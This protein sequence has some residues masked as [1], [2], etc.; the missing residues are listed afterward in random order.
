MAVECGGVNKTSS[1][2]QRV[3]MHAHW[4]VSVLPATHVSSSAETGRMLSGQST[5]QTTWTV[6]DVTVVAV[7]RNRSSCCNVICV[8]WTA[9]QRHV[10]VRPSIQGHSGGIKWC[11]L[12]DNYRCFASFSNGRCVGLC[13]FMQLL[14]QIRSVPVSND[15]PQHDR[16]TRNVT[17][18]GV[19]SLLLGL[20]KLLISIQ[21]YKTVQ[22][23]GQQT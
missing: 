16:G 15:M 23:L 1:S 17:S 20:L 9:R 14:L 2:M 8:Y 22:V 12:W 18:I 21:K 3:K 7:T 11:R 6:S 19:Q 5:N 13:V 4:S 10:A